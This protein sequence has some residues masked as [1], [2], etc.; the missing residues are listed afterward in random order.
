MH[1]YVKKTLPNDQ[2]IEV[3]GASWESNTTNFIVDLLVIKK[4]QCCSQIIH[5]PTYMGT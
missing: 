1:K 2:I 4:G 5:G 3:L